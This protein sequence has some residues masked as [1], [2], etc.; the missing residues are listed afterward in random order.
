MGAVVLIQS[1]A[2]ELPHA[3]GVAIKE[4]EKKMIKEL[5]RRLDAQ[6]KKLEDF[7][8]DLENIKNNQT[9]MKNTIIEIKYTLAGEFPCGSLG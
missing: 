2:W 9:E 4:K 1:L 3:L 7:N 8:K 6:S 5:E